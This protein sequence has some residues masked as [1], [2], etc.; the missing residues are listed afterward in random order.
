MVPRVTSQLTCAL[1]WMA[2]K[3]ARRAR[4]IRAPNQA[5]SGKI[6]NVLPMHAPVFLVTKHRAHAPMKSVLMVVAHGMARIAITLRP[7]KNCANKLAARGL[8]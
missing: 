7:L 4:T 1:S 3:Q 2:C 5:D 6:I 8:K